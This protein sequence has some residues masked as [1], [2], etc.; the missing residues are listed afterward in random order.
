MIDCTL[1]ISKGICDYKLFF[2]TRSFYPYFKQNSIEILV[3][4]SVL[5]KSLITW[6]CKF[7]N[8]MFPNRLLG[9]SYAL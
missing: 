2:L 7:L 9:I 4:F 3:E 5:V 6:L 1:D 8:F